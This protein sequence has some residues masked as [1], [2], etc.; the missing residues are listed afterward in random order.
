MLEAIHPVEIVLAFVLNVGGSLAHIGYIQIITSAPTADAEWMVMTMYDDLV[1]EL[2]YL[3]EYSKQINPTPSGIF[4]EV[5][6]AIEEL[7]KQLDEETE[8]ATA[9]SCYV[10]QWIPVTERL[11]EEYKDVLC[12]YEYF[13]YGDYNCM[14]RTI[15]R[16]YYGNGGWG[17]EAGQGHKNK[18]LA[19][20]PLPEPPKEQT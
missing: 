15:D 8:Y 2:R 19:W 18:V 9:L 14:F 6:D 20:M 17:G 7:E 3:D 10:P 5:A 12:Y 16:G 4:R 11:P 1:K 13:R